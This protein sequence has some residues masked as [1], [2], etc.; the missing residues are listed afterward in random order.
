M[1]AGTRRAH[2]PLPNEQMGL[3]QATTGARVVLLPT[4]DG[5]DQ[6]LAG[7]ALL[8]GASQAAKSG[9]QRVGGHGVKVVVE[10]LGQ[11]GS[12]C[13]KQFE[14]GES[15]MAAAVHLLAKKKPACR[16]VARPGSM[17]GCTKYSPVAC[18]S[19]IGSCKRTAAP[20]R[21]QT[22]RMPTHP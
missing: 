19:S 20:L 16:W 5:R 9:G 21:R 6:G 7:A 22:Q 8:D 18:R 13:S 15:N 1:P 2:Q 4:R 14:G 3:R 12:A 11:V 17:Q 10:Q